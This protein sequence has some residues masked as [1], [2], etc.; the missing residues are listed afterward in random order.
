MH[1]IHPDKRKHSSC[2]DSELELVVFVVQ[3]LALLQDVEEHCGG[4]DHSQYEQR[5][6]EE[7]DI[8]QNL[9]RDEITLLPVAL[10]ENED[11]SHT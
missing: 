2:L 8:S 11:W 4:S 5:V 9:H 10:Y 6:P 3:I 1:Q 7:L